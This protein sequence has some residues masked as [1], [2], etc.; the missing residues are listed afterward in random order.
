MLEI[1]FAFSS[2]AHDSRGIAVSH[3]KRGYVAH[4]NTARAN[5]G[6]RAD[7]LLMRN[8][9][10]NA[11]MRAFTNLNLPASEHAWSETAEVIH[12]AIVIERSAG[13]DHA[14]VANFRGVANVRTGHQECAFTNAGRRRN[15]RGGMLDSREAIAVAV[16]G[17]KRTENAPAL[18]VVTD[19]QGNVFAPLTLANILSRS[20]RPQHFVAM[21][22]RS[23]GRAVIEKSNRFVAALRAN[24]FQDNA[25]IE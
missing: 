1:L 12:D 25:S 21:L 22:H 7:F 14:K 19:R 20:R 16:P 17:K 3:G 13:I 18:P 24:H 23:S 15:Q 2:Q 11:K 9:D 5:D 8:A 4:H 6:M 10:A